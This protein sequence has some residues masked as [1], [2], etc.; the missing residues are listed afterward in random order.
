MFATLI[1]EDTPWRIDTLGE[2]AGFWIVFGIVQFF[3]FWIGLIAIVRSTHYTG[4][5]KF[6][7]FVVLLFVPILGGLGFLTIGRKAKLVRSAD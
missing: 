3:V 1:T 5:G 6:L 7:W 4:G 2:F